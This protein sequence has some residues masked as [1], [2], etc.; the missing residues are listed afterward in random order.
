MGRK[1]PRID[2]YIAG[3]GAF[4]RPILSHLRSLVHSASPGVTET[5]KWGM[6]FFEYHGIVGG[7][8]AF[9]SHC[10]FFLWKPSKLN[11]PEGILKKKERAAMGQFGRLTGL[12]DLPADRHLREF[13]RQIC[14]RNEAGELPKP[15]RR[16]K[17]GPVVV[18]AGLMTALRKNRRALRAFGEFS[19]AHRREYSEWI[20]EAKR[21]ETRAKR[22]ATAVRWISTGKGRNWRYEKKG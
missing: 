13:I 4:A 9:K 7:M 19:D 22:I 2:K 3:A 6:P 8:G 21:E 20:S 15:V 5:M 12:K 16:T 11:D 17:K 10:T 18:P 1:D 14:R